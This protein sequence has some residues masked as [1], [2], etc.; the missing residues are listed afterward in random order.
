M[1]MKKIHIIVLAILAMTLVS[2]Q[3]YLNR[4]PLD[5]N[6][7]ATNWSNEASLST[8]ANMLYETFDGYGSGWSR[9]Q[10]LSSGLSDD[11]CCD[12]YTYPTQTVPSSSSSW[13][14]PYSWIRRSNILLARVDRVPN[15]SESAANHWRGVARFFRGK[16]HYELV[17]TY[18][19]VVWIDS[20]VDIDD[21][22]TLKKARDPRVTVMKNVCADLQFAAENIPYS[23]DNTVNNMCAYALLSRAALYEAAWQKY[24]EKNSENAK[25]FYNIAKNAANAV[26]A[27][28]HYTI[29]T[30]Y[31]ANYI[32][33]DLKGNTEMILYKIYCYT[34]EKAAVTLAHSMQGWCNSSSKTWGLTKS[35]VESFANSDGLPIYMSTYS[36]ATIA[37]VFKNRDARLS[38]IASPT[39]ICPVGW[40]Y[41]QGVN[42]STAYWTNKFVDQSDYGTVTWSAPYN[43]SDAP[44]FSYSEV[45]ENY[46]EACAELE[47]LGAGAMSQADL[48]KSINIVRAKHGNLPALTYAGTG[49]VS[50]G[51]KTITKDPKNTF[52][53]SNMLWEIR[54]E[55]RSELMCDGFREDDL[56]RWKMG[57][58]L[59]FASNPECYEGASKAAITAYYEATKDLDLYKKDVFSDVL[60]GNFWSSDGKYMSAFDIT[61]NVRVFADKNYLEPI[62][63]AQM[64]LNPNLTQNPG[65]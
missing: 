43:T 23:T 57:S 21:S 15:L 39:V 59:D 14:S 19:D 40:A 41:T 3:D 46:A 62:P 6:S 34:G 36:D 35:A 16:E 12:T 28:G 58:L 33:K 24:H 31:Q 27:S 61:K 53:I 38:F 50:V 25:Y 20:E 63:S 4:V 47:D 37:D 11:Y 17:R 7:D 42:S 9:G 56:M 52:G 32:S 64:T 1:I 44:I 13:S 22:T 30:N 10:Y 65:W 48:D 8:F 29:T 26:I 60:S 2:C 5:A 18:G 55:R 45:L 54:R 51:G 49:A